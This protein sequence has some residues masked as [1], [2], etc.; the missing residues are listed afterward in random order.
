MSK[1]RLVNQLQNLALL[2]LTVS[3]LF[4]LTR[5][6]MVQNIRW[7]DQVPGLFAGGPPAGGQEAGETP[8]GMFASVHLMV[9]GDSQYGRCGLL[10]TGADDAG[11]QSI[12]P[13]FREALGSAVPVGPAED[14]AF[15]AALEG[16]GVY[17]ELSAGPLP[18]EA[19]GIW[20]G[21]ETGEEP[22]FSMVLR[23]MA[24]TAGGSEAAELYLL[25]DQGGIT[26]CRTALPIS[27]VQSVCD[28][29]SPNGADF[30][31]KTHD[32]L[33]PYT[34][35]ASADP[36]PDALPSL[37]AGYSVYN[38]L[39]ALGFNAHTL[40]RYRESGGAEVVEESPCTLRIG[41]EGAVSFTSRGVDVPSLFRASGPGLREALAAAWRL[42]S[43][44]TEGT[45]ASPVYLSGVQAREEGWRL[46]FRYQADGVPVVF[47]NEEDALTVAFTG[48][49]ITS[50]T[51]RCRSYALAEEEPAE[52]LPAFIAQAIAADYP[53]SRLSVSYVDDGSERLTAQWRRTD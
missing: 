36:A 41:P 10:C 15:R 18:L 17:L 35:L 42:V 30:A 51:Y 29:F 21:E 40:S 43:A 4:L 20:L 11:L 13:L 38:L 45:G 50:F 2:L 23:A 6:P 49:A 26:L 33:S 24:L 16:P 22:G 27:A 19:V 1:K 32:M 47:S 53:G 5:L 25:D 7:P 48:G 39:T 14:E 12:V 34:V 52:L 46:S 44:L 8:A 37:P 31:Y 3:A 28:D 9:T